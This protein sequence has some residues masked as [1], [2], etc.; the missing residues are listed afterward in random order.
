MASQKKFPEGARGMQSANDYR[1]RRLGYEA[2]NIKNALLKVYDSIALICE[3]QG[4]PRTPNKTIL[5][6]YRSLFEPIQGLSKLPSGDFLATHMLLYLTDAFWNECALDKKFVKSKPRATS[7]PLHQFSIS[8]DEAVLGHL[9]TRWVASD[10]CD[11]FGW[12][13]E[14]Y[15]THW[16]LARNRELA[17]AL[18]PRELATL[19]GIKNRVFL[20]SKPGD[21]EDWRPFP[22][23]I[24]DFDLNEID[25]DTL[26]SATGWRLCKFGQGCQGHHENANWAIESEHQLV[27]LAEAILTDRCATATTLDQIGLGRAPDLR[28]S[29]RTEDDERR[30]KMFPR[31]PPLENDKW[32]AEMNGGAGG[33][34]DSM[35]HDRLLLRA[36]RSGHSVTSPHWSWARNLVEK[37]RAEDGL[38]G[39]HTRCDVC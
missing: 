36:W 14:L 33:L 8:L 37:K 25:P 39:R 3:H 35:V 22:D 26:H 7:V 9:R 13:L 5:E 4:H 23:D 2:Q 18:T 24:R 28:D 30:R 11:D 21:E 15:S 20:F 16:P 34:V 38:R 19:G 12:I 27:Q 1:T 10:G 17:Q 32:E 31:L 6:A 29:S